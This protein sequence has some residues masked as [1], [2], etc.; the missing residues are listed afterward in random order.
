[1]LKQ[2]GVKASVSMVEPSLDDAFSILVNSGQEVV[3][4]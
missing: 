3:R 4:E 1:M 2:A